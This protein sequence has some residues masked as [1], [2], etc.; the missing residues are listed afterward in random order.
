MRLRVNGANMHARGANIIPMEEFEGRQTAV[1]YRSM[2]QSAVDARMNSVRV[3]GGGVFLPEL[4]YD[5]CDELG[6]VI[7]LHGTGHRAPVFERVSLH[8]CWS[9]LTPRECDGFDAKRGW[10][11]ID[12][13]W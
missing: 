7:A 11:C 8:I 13:S 12:W 2:L 10:H 5:T 9:G 6:L 1:A 4:F 3:W